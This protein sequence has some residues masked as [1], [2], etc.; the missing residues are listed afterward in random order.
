MIKTIVIRFLKHSKQLILINL[1]H[2]FAIEADCFCV[3]M[4]V[5]V[6]V[7]CNFVTEKLQLNELIESGFLFF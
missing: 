5:F 3:S 6:S 7:G 2:E 1:L 4:G